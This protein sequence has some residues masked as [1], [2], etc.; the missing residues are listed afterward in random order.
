M[1]EVEVVSGARALR[2]DPFRIAEE[3]RL[4]SQLYGLLGLL[5]A[6]EPSGEVLAIVRNLQGD[7][8]ELGL[9]FQSLAAEA[10]RFSLAAIH[11]EFNDLF[12]GVGRGELVPYGSYYLTGFLNEKPL[13]KLRIAMREL[14]VRRSESVKEPEDNIGILMEIMGGLIEGTFGDVADEATQKA[15]FDAHIG[16]WASHFFKD[17]ET[18]EGARFYRP[19]GRIGRLFM[20]IERTAFSME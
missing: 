7:D 13:A 16:S 15:F 9:A 5:L 14:N 1:Q 10:E 3:D 6:R 4:R 18:A 17:L 12:I 19:V 2:A 8:S 11:R 20:E